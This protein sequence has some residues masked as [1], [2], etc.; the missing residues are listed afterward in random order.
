MVDLVAAIFESVTK[1]D[2]MKPTRPIP[3]HRLMVEKRHAGS[4]RSHNGIGNVIEGRWKIKKCGGKIKDGPSVEK[5]TKGA[6]IR[7]QALI[8]M[9]LPKRAGRR[10]PKTD[11][12]YICQTA[13]VSASTL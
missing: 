6:K 9:Q 5:A 2:W 7:C 4:H 1:A 3:R 11:V 12:I 13:V 10:L 8:D